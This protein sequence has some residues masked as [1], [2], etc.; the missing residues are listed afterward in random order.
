MEPPD[1]GR[2]HQAVAAQEIVRP[3]AAMEPP[4]K[5]RKHDEL[6]RR[7]T[8]NFDAAME[9]PDKGR[10]HP[11]VTAT[12]PVTKAAPQWSRPIQG[13]TAALMSARASVKSAP[14]VKARDT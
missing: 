2:K 6:N 12:S 13:G 14:L 10:K 3:P 8:A 5:G 1:K 9:P 7:I 11:P 4:D